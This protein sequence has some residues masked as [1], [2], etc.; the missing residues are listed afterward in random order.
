MPFRGSICAIAVA[1]L[2][3][4]P[5]QAGTSS[6]NRSV[7]AAASSVVRGSFWRTLRA[8]WIAESASCVASLDLCGSFA[9]SMVASLQRWTI[10]RSPLH[11]D[12][13]AAPRVR[14]LGT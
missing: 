8:S 2:L 10:C 14:E 11:H 13:W 7:G 3:S 5:A 1:A 9:M 12:Q 6:W 4:S